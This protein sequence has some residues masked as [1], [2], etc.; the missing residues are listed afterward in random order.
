MTHRETILEATDGRIVPKQALRERQSKK[1]T[2]QKQEVPSTKGKE[3]DTTIKFKIQY[4]LEGI[5]KEMD[6][7]SKA[8]MDAN[9]A[10]NVLKDK[11][12]KLK[13]H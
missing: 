9:V 3:I 7:A 6:M 2:Q 4:A 5:T 13:K 11:M 10:T 8:K 1:E 12:N